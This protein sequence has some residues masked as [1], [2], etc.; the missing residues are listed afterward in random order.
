ME[1]QV[2]LLN[3]LRLGDAEQDWE[4]FYYAYAEMI[5]RY[6]RKLGLD[7]NAAN[8]VL[9]D[10]MVALMSALKKFEY[11]PRRGKF[12]SFLFTIVR[13]STFRRINRNIRRKEV[14]TDAPFAENEGSLMD[15]LA[16]PEGPT[17]S[18][19]DE[20]QWRQSI[21]EHC[22]DVIRSDPKVQK[23][24]IDIFIAYVVEEASVKEVA[25]RF[26]LS[27]NNV[28]QIKNRMMKRLQ[29]EVEKLFPE[30]AEEEPGVPDDG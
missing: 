8:D 12:R 6:A 17:V 25:Q 26:K 13:R 27:E 23:D 10:T 11:D 9:Q 30:E 16:A 29:Q 20:Q 3:R 1:T 19:Q 5:V 4:R 21:M 18:D 24:T 14:S 28:Y 22:L 2:S 15:I 7:E